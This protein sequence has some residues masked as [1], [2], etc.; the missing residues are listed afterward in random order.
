MNGPNRPR[1]LELIRGIRRMRR[2]IAVLLLLIPALAVFLSPYAA[3]AEASSSQEASTLG[4]TISDVSISNVGHYGATVLWKTDSSATSQ[5]FYDTNYH[6]DIADY[7]YHTS[8]DTDLNLEHSVR[9]TGLS[10]FTTYHYRVRSR[11][12]A[13]SSVAVSDDHTFRTSRTSSR[14]ASTPDYDRGLLDTDLFGNHENYPISDSGEILET[15][16]AASEDGSLYLTIEQGTI[17]LDSNGRPLQYLEVSVDKNP[18]PPPPGG[19]IIAL[20]YDFQPSGAVFDPPITLECRCDLSDIYAGVDEEYLVFAYYDEEL[21]VWVECPGTYDWETH[22]LIVSIYHFT[23]FALIAYETSPEPA[24]EPIP[25]PAPEPPQPTPT[26]Q[27]PQPTPTPQQ[28]QP[29]TAPSPPGVF[30][31]ILAAVLGVTLLLAI[32]FTRGLQSR[33]KNED[34]IT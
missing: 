10:S 23:C 9:L 15:V 5:V 3:H 18:P 20:A 33:K 11:I 22:R 28:P 32:F 12:P 27:Q 24:P 14:S 21:G 29:Q 8:E 19:H 16:E 4:F 25:P 6:D 34:T 1:V 2:M 17:A 26:P 30:W 13:D 31:G 7:A